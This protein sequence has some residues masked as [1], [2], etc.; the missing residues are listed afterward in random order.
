MVVV[1]LM[2]G[3]GNQMFQYAIGRNL[4]CKWN[5]ELVLDVSFLLDRTPRKDF[6]FRDFDLDLF[7]LDSYGFFNDKMA[8][9]FNKNSIFKKESLKIEEKS[10]QYYPLIEQLSKRDIYL[11]GYWQSY[12]YF[13][14][15]EAKIRSEFKF[16]KKLNKSQLLL[17][18]KILQ[19]SSVCINF[20]RTDY[21]T[22][23]S[24]LKTH[25]VPSLNYYY[26]AVEILLKI[27]G[28]DLEFFVF[29][30]D[31]EWCETNFKLDKKI[32]FIKH[33]LY[34]GERFSSYL[35]LMTCCKYFIIPNSTFA[36][37]AAWL[38][39][40]SEKIVIIPEKWFVDSVLQ[41]QIQDLHPDNWIK[42]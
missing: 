37:W 34:K 19:T 2:G 10:F 13:S 17:S 18:D 39:T 8:R 31:I 1:K 38:S 30:D 16:S 27:I 23:P 15:I 33:D 9:K 14:K 11:D 24:A 32:H 40:F 5:T 4:A 12:K 28:E 6:I 35:Q 7:Q 22:V 26:E 41:T 42:I 20:R 29:S 36:W 3:L 25:G 21:L